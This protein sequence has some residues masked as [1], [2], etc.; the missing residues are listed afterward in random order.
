MKWLVRTRTR[1]LHRSQVGTS[2]LRVSISVLVMISAIKNLSVAS[3]SENKT[4]HHSESPILSTER[5]FLNFESEHS[6]HRHKWPVWYT[7]V[8][9]VSTTERLCPASEL[10]HI[11]EWPKGTVV[12]RGLHNRRPGPYISWKNAKKTATNLEDSH[13]PQKKRKKHME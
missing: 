12:P 1:T 9:L 13:R 4:L 11:Q 5:F 3:V 2:S 8:S 10:R 7:L 6:E